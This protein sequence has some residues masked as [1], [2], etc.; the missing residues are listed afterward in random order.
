MNKFID[1][2][3]KREVYIDIYKTFTQFNVEKC[4]I[5]GSSD[6]ISIT[7]WEFIQD[8]NQD[9]LHASITENI[10][11]H[12]VNEIWLKRKIS[13][14]GLIHSHINTQAYLSPKDVKTA[15]KILQMNSQLL[16]LYMLIFYRSDSN[17]LYG[18]QL[19]YSKEKSFIIQFTQLNWKII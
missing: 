14:I 12:I 3:I 8:Q 19:S 17:E 1:V 15:S 5:L 2:A 10:L 7:D 9:Q 13:F 18:Y 11:H 6:G 16:F 4:G